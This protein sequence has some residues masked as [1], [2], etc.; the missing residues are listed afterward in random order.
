MKTIINIDVDETTLKQSKDLFKTLGLDLDTAIELFFK[1][2][3]EEK[4][5]PFLIT[6]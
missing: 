5:I 4:G 6:K 3:V 1:K 2:C